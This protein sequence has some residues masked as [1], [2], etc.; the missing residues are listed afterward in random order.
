MDII[1]LSI[2]FNQLETKKTIHI[3][4]ET[5]IQFFDKINRIRATL[6]FFPF[7]LKLDIFFKHFKCYPRSPLYT[8]PALL[9][10]PH[11]PTSWPWHSP[12]QGHIIFTRPRASPP[13]YC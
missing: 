12:I 3:I 2:E 10:N 9:P 11:T 1:K 4:N 7:F 8:P 5:K 6:S 13:S